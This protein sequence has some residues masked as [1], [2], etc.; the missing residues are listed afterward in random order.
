M[1]QDLRDNGLLLECNNPETNIFQTGDIICA[2]NL[3][4]CIDIRTNPQNPYVDD[5]YYDPNVRYKYI[6]DKNVVP[7]LPLK[8]KG[9]QTPIYGY[10]TDHVFRTAYYN[11]CYNQIGIYDN[12]IEQTDGIFDEENPVWTM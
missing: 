5:L 6:F 2:V 8:I 9:Q 3:I 11:A 12:P 10:T 7:L 4:D 1:I